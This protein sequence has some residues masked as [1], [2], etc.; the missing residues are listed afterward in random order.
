MSS[1]ETQAALSRAFELVEAGNNEEARAILDPILAANP[2]NADAWWVYAH[3]ADDPAEGQRAL[4]KVVSINPEYPGASDLLEMARER[5]AEEEAA[6][7]SRPQVPPSLPEADFAEPDFG[8]AEPPQLTR[9]E[10]GTAAASGEHRRSP[11]GPIIAVVIIVV[12]VAL[13]V[14]T[15][16]GGG[17]TP[18]P[19]ATPTEIV[20]VIV[21]PTQEVAQSATELATPPTVAVTEQMTELATIGSAS[22][23]ELATS[24][25]ISATETTAAST[26]QATAA[27]G[28]A[29]AEATVGDYA[30]LQQA[31][32][33]FPI[34]PDGIQETQTSF[35]QTLQVTACSAAGREMR[36]LL[37]NLMNAF[38]LQSQNLDRSIKAISVHLVNCDT[39]TSLVTVAVGRESSQAFATGLLTD[40]EFAARWKPQ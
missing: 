8:L 21:V 28:S 37:P 27:T 16:L 17:N 26:E 18:A 10:T 11:I 33:Q 31:L 22:A 23:T 29:T 25:P 40:A 19:T 3:A 12:L 39:N 4:E 13:V 34:A 32:A 14:V 6:M 35:G 2:N 5:F 38:A 9:Q 7:P 30:A 20:S 15:Q 1:D 24:A 36:T